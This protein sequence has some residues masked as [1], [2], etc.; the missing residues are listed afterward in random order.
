MVDTPCDFSAG[1]FVQ[2]IVVSLAA[3][4]FK[5]V[6][7]EFA[8]RGY[9]TPRMNATGIDPIAG[10]IL[11]GLIW[12]TWHIP[13]WS[14]LL[15]RAALASFTTQSL[16]IFVPTAVLGITA[17]GIIFGEIRLITG[18][19]WPVLIMHAVNN[20]VIAVVLTGGFFQVARQTGFLFTPGME[21]ILSIILITLAGL[22]LHQQRIRRAE[23]G[24][25]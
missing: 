21:G 7:E 18:S 24:L 12:G 16:A 11:V 4:F 8:W 6:F 9:L 10:H 25:P 14:G 19:T 23:S 15:D 17:A 22:W 3:N 1:P 5:N 13:Y 2:A 20:S